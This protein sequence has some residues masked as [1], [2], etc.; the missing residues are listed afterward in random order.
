MVNKKRA[1]MVG[2]DNFIN[3]DKI[4]A[5]VSFDNAFVRRV[6]K[7]T[8]EKFGVIDATQGNKTRS[9]IFLEDERVVLSST[10]KKTLYK[11]FSNIEVNNG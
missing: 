9:V 1:L 10:D 4:L 5:I 11:R 3:A 2:Y 8:K 6:V 7:K